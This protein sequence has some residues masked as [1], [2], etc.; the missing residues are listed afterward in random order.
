M[1]ASISL[2]TLLIAALL[3]FPATL[4]G[5][6]GQTPVDIAKEYTRLCKSGGVSDAVVQYWDFATLLEIICKD[7]LDR[8]SP[9]EKA[10]MSGMLREAV[11]QIMSNPQVASEMKKASFD[12]FEQKPMAPTVT[13]V[14]FIATFSNG[15]SVSNTYIFER[16]EDGGS[17]RIVNAACN[18]GPMVGAGLRGS[19]LESKL[20]PLEFFKGLLQAQAA[21]QP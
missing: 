10:A 13:A 4:R 18:G 5:D 1:R 7:D 15:K 11:R 6:V 8:Y 20:P 2:P 12:N 19:Y 21:A 3:T 14:R 9:R 16:P 17:W